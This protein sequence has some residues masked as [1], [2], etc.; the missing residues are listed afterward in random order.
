MPLFRRRGGNAAASIAGE[1]ARRPAYR[2]AASRSGTPLATVEVDASLLGAW[3]RDAA[4]SLPVVAA[5][6]NLVCGTVGQLDVQRSRAGMP[7]E[8]GALLTQ[9]DPDTPWPA[10]IERTVDDLAFYGRAYWLVLAFDGVAT[11]R[12]PRGMPVRARHVPAVSVAPQVNPDLAAYT[13]IDS[14]LVGGTRIDPSGVIPFDAGHEGILRFGSRTIGAGIALEDAARRLAD[15]ELP[16]GTLTNTGHELSKD[17]AETLV[18]G[19]QS[20]RRANGIAFLQGITYERQSLSPGDLQLVEA[21]ATA[22]TD[23]ARLWNMPVA[24]VAASPTGNATAMLYANLSSTQALLLN[25]AVAPYLRAIEAAL[26]SEDVTA[27]GQKVHFTTGQWLRTDPQA[28]ADYVTSLEA[29]GIISV[30]EGRSFLGLPP[31]AGSQPSL[32]PGRV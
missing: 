17:E 19:F 12:N 8:P 23:Q 3:G 28:S 11:D 4:M 10:H 31:G 26:S 27:R 21:R 13:R 9:P 16:A 1:L 6:R 25:T 18:E 32:T 29:A 5:C 2:L 30:D 24:L 22:A 15:V 20:A 14:Y 7:L